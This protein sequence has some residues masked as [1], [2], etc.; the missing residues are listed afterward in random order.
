MPKT[1][2]EGAED[3]KINNFFKILNMLFKMQI[4]RNQPVKTC[5]LEKRFII[6]SNL[7]IY[8]FDQFVN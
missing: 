2:S 3:P 1:K 7:I 8:L 6:I 4:D 5:Q